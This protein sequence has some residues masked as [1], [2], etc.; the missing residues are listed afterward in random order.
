MF[1]KVSFHFNL[2][3]ERFVKRDPKQLRHCEFTQGEFPDTTK[4]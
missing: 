3:F 4:Q 2:Y 1:L